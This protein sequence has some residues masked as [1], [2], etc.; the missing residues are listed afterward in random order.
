MSRRRPAAPARP[1]LAALAAAAAL[2]ACGRGAPPP[3]AAPPAPPLAG[4]RL[5]DPVPV[6]HAPRTVAA[7]TLKPRQ[8]AAL[9]M[10]V[11]GTLARVAVARGQEVQAGALLA[12]LDDAAAAAARRQADAAVAAAR[13]QLALAEDGL[14]RVT[15]IHQGQASSEAQLV[16]ARAQRDLAA[17]QLAAAE[18]Q[19]EQARV[20]LDHHQLRAPF[21]GVITRVPDGVGV[22]VAPGVPLVSLV[23]TRALTLETSVTQEEAA[24]LR[25][26]ARLAVHVPAAD[27]R[28]EE[29][30]VAAVVPVADPAT[31]RVP[32]EIAVPN[33]D[34]R[35]TAN[36]Y[37]RAE[38]PAAA[39]RDAWRV[40][41]AAL[42][43]REAGH[44]AWVAGPDGRAH[45]LP[46]RLLA[47][48]G[49]AAV[50]VPAAGGPWPPGLRVVALPP[51]GIA[52]GAP[53]AE[54]AR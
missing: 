23:A 37:A 46:V 11:P 42:L 32:V 18:A 30:T 13:A 14:A 34:G 5:V 43:Q 8:Q 7:G 31:T 45:A 48:D 44:A 25:R 22:A 47:E 27:A 53:V 26:G 50:V 35:F 40:P 28:T 39:P 33:G 20:H 17:A 1:A 49:A 10:S 4:S 15:A 3:P 52:E 19:A 16:Q 29:A 2:A 12:A 6:R 36:A 38:L 51:V 21:A 9:A 41:A 24:A 54:A